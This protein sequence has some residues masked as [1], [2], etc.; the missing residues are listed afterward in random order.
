ME[1]FFTKYQGTLGFIGIVIGVIALLYPIY[2]SLRKQFL[3]RKDNRFERY[4]K[5]MGNLVS[6][7]L[8]N[9]SPMLDQQIAIIYELRN[10]PDYYDVSHRILTGLKAQWNR[11]TRDRLAIEIDLTLD[12][13]KKSEK[14]GLIE[15]LFDHIISTILI[16]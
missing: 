7:T 10:F 13:I 14:R 12:H 1:N 9:T 5:F 11:P 4:Y 16:R 3:N 15:K 6:G 2:S 8:P